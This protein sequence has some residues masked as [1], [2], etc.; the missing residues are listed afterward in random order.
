MR[1]AASSICGWGGPAPSHAGHGRNRQADGIA[2]DR[3]YGALITDDGLA[4]LKD[5]QKLSGM[6]LGGTP[7]TD[8]GL[9]HLAKLKGLRNI[10]P[11]QK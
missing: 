11:S 6:G 7:I 8:E 1:R 4:Q 3:L 10:L 2:R 9:D 5:L